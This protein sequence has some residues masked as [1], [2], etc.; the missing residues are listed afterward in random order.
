MSAPVLI[1]DD[2]TMLRHLLVLQLDKLGLEA[3]AAASGSEAIK[4]V[5][6]CRYALIVM[7]IQ[8]PEMDGYQATQAI[9]TD[10]KQQGLDFVP[11]VAITA[12]ATKSEVIAQGLSDYVQKPASVEVLEMIVKRWISPSAS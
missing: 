9:R 4:L 12:G 7:D 6:D 11:I 1:V 2:D 8:M 3:H 5:Q 10:E